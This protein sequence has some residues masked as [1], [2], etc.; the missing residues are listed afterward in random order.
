[1]NKHHAVRGIYQ[2]TIDYD[3]A[4]RFEPPLPDHCVLQ[5]HSYFHPIDLWAYTTDDESA[6]GE[7]SYQIANLPDSRCGISL[8]SHWINISP[9]SGWLGSC[10]VV[11]RVSDSIKPV[12][13]SFTITVV[14]VVGNVYMPIIM[15]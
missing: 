15:R 11:I 9:Q 6:D 5:D 2:N 3:T 4:P 12:T 10:D 8:E 1:V 14:P 13:D 7:L